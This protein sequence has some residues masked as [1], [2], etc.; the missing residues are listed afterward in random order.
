VLPLDDV[1]LAVHIEEPLENLGISHEF[2][3]S[4]GLRVKSKTKKTLYQD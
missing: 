1:M 4:L 3:Q 2:P